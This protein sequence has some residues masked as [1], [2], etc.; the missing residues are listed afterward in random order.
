MCITYNGFGFGCLQ[1]LK[2]AEK[3]FSITSYQEQMIKPE[4]QLSMLKPKQCMHIHAHTI[5]KHAEAFKQDLCACQEAD[6]SCFI[7]QAKNADCRINAIK[8]HDKMRN[9]LRISKNY[10]GPLRLNDVECSLPVYCLH[11]LQQNE[12]MAYI[13]TWLS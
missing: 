1:K 8:N 5:T 9:L 3:N 6:R 2:N 11:A 13:K 12:L 10:L 4:M 7:G